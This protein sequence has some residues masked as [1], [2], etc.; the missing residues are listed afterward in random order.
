MRAGAPERGLVDAAATA[1]MNA[2]EGET[3]VESEQE[4]SGP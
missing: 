3:A 4:V 2:D 1:A